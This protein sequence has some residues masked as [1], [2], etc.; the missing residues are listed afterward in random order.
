MW[1]IEIPNKEEF[2]KEL[3]IPWLRWFFNHPR[4]CGC[5]FCRKNKAM[6]QTVNKEILDLLEKYTKEVKDEESK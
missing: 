5:Y 3:K 4:P 2:K 6:R 1:I